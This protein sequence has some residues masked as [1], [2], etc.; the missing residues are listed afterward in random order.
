MIIDGAGNTTIAGQITGGGSLT[1]DGAGTLLLSNANNTYSGN[2]TIS[3]GTIQDGT[4]DALPASN[5]TNLTISANGT[6]DLHGYNQQLGSLN[7][8]AGATVTDNNA[9]GSSVLTVGNTLPSVFAGTITDST[10]GGGG[11][12]SLVSSAGTLTL[13]GTNSYA[14]GTTIDGGITVINTA[15][16]LGTQA[17]SATI[18]NAILEVHGTIS[19]TTR[20]FELGDPNST[21]QVDS[22]DTYEIDG[23]IGGSGGT[24]NKTGTGTLDLTGNNTYTGNTAISAGTLLVNNTTGSATGNGTVTVDEHRDP[25]RYRHRQRQHQRRERRHG[26]SGQQ[27]WHPHHRRQR[28]LCCRL[29][30]QRGVERDQRLRSTCYHRRCQPRQ[31]HPHRCARL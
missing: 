4:N 29:V 24:L 22:G 13:S 15:D 18:N 6:L 10:G 19:E 26:L 7:G 11:A 12:L 2:T 31:Q 3:A 8:V 30:L 21:I 28:D 9:S 20:G 1:K 14:G 16:S 5:L 17:G 25:G 23:T 27:R